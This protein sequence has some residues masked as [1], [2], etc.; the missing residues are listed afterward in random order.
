MIKGKGLLRARVARGLKSDEPHVDREHGVLHGYAVIMKGILDDSRW[1]EID[2]TALEQV[3]TLGNKGKIG[4]KSRFGH[5]NMSSEA[6]G[7]FV[8]RAKNFRRDG[9]IVR[10]DLHFDE[11]AYETPHG[12]LADYLMKRAETDP[13]S[14]GSSLAFEYE[15]DRF[16]GYDGDGMPLYQKDDKGNA[17]PPLVRFTR[18][19]ASDMVDEPAANE[20]LFGESLFGGNVVLSAEATKILDTVLAR[21]DAVDRIMVFL[22]RYSSNR[23]AQGATARPAVS[24]TAGEGSS[25]PIELKD[26]TLE[27]LQAQR[28]ELIEQVAALNKPATPAPEALKAAGDA[29]TQAERIR[30]Q[31]ILACG[32]TL[33]LPTEARQCIAEGL[34]VADAKVKLSE[35]R[36]KATQTASPVPQGSDASQDRDL[37]SLPLDDRCKAEFERDAKI[38]AEFRSLK[39]YVAFKRAEARGTVKILHAGKTA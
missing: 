25:M 6:L 8:G 38:R 39:H 37:S 11:S 30:V 27:M 16:D 5:P 19:F 34:S 22:S 14:F 13:D 10:A 24:E 23:E 32:D 2:D 35:A 20:G 15:L 4:I 12:D 21:P 31:E 17:L 33:Q 1:W 18:L 3:M 9:D 29:A 28:P 36:L 7:T 26:I